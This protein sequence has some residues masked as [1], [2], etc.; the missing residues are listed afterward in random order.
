MNGYVDGKGRALV[1]ISVRSTT[2]TAPQ[3]LKAW[4]DT[5]F[6]G[7]LVL[8]QSEIDQLGLPQSG[9]VKGDLANGSIVNM[10]TYSCLLEWFGEDREL[11]VVA[12]TGECPLL[13]VGLLLG[14]DLHISYRSCEIA[15]E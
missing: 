4:I 5:G 2:A 12:N 9:T 13:G 14:H 15:I 6:N 8:P 11:E 7:D 3:E 10:K 1:T